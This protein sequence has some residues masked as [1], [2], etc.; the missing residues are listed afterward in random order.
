MD[1]TATKDF[2]NCDARG[3][4]M[5]DGE[6]FLGQVPV[7]YLLFLEK[8]LTSL[9]T[10]VTKMVELDPA[11]RWSWD[12]NAAL[13][14]SQPVQTHRTKKMQKP[15][16]LYDATPEHAAQ[17][18]LI[19]EDVVIGYWSTTKF[20]GAVPRPRKKQLL[21]RIRILQDAVKFA[22]VQANAI[23]VEEKKVGTKV[24]DFIFA[25]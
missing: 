23:E 1:V 9:H 18:Q 19:T 4:V 15:I 2:A 11:E 20:S 10:F 3:D 12:E 22:R 21:E 7:P 17:T 24:L 14:R 6:V 5:V 16:V 13:F 25:E 8:E